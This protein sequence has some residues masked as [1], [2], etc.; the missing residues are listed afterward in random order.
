MNY[1]FVNARRLSLVLAVMCGLLI[2]AFPHWAD[3]LKTSGQYGLS[4][5]VSGLSAVSSILAGTIGFITAGVS[6]T[7]TDAILF[8]VGL[9]SDVT[10][11]IASS[12]LAEAAFLISAIVTTVGLVTALLTASGTGLFW[13]AVAGAGLSVLRAFLRSG[14]PIRPD[15]TLTS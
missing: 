1:A 9:A 15:R 5:T 13:A 2:M 3:A 14:P 6:N 11:G 4:N 7:L 8:W 10:N 12:N